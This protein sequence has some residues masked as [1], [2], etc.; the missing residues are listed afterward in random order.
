[1]IRTCYALQNKEE[2]MAKVTRTARQLEAMI[3]NEAR[4]RPE[5]SDLTGV[6]IARNSGDPDWMVNQLQNSTSPMCA[7]RVESIA[8]RLQHRYRLA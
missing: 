7:Q 6:G 3:M 1:M 4:A 8:S 5:C 2:A